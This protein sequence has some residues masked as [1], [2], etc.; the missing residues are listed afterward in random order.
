[1]SRSAEVLAA[2]RELAGPGV[3]QAEIAAKAG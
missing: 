1:M 3:K 2:V